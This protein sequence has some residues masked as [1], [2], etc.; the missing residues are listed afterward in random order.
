[1][2]KIGYL[3]LFLIFTMTTSCISNK[4]NSNIVYFSNSDYKLTLDG[5][6]GSIR[7]IEKD[8]YLMVD[9]AGTR[10]PL[11]SVRLRDAQNKGEIH[12]FNAL[13]A[14][15]CQIGQRKDLITM[16]FSDFPQ[17]DVQV[18]VTVAVSKDSPYMR[19]N[20][21]ITNNTPYLIDHIDFPNVVVPNDLVANGGTGRIFWPAQEGCLIE[22]MDIRA[23]SAWLRYTPIEYP[24]RGFGGRYPITAQMQYMAYYNAN[25]GLYM[26]TH[27]EDFHPKGIEYNPTE[28]NGIKLDFRLFA[29]GSGK[30]TYKLPYD[31]V[32]GVF[33]G[34]WY[35]ASMIYRDWRESSNMPVPP[36]IVDNPRLPDWYFES[37]VVVTYPVRGHMDTG[38]MS[39]NEFFPYTKGLKYI[40]KYND[41]FDSKIMA[42]LMHWEGSAPWAPPYVWPPYGGEKLYQ[43]FVDSLHAK[44]N[45][46]GLYASGIGYTLQSNNDPA[47]NMEQEFREKHLD[48]IMN[49][50][51]D[52]TLATNGV[53]TGP[54]AQRIGYDMCPANEFVKEV[55]QDQISKIVQSKT[56]YIQYFD[57]NL[58][59]ASYPC[60]GTNHGHPYGPGA[61]QSDAMQDIYKGVQEILDD[62]GYKPLIGCEGAAAEPYLSYLLY[63]DVRSPVNLMAGVPVPAFAFVYHE[64]VNNFMGNQVGVSAA[65]DISQSPANYLQR[66][67]YA[68]CAG[69]MLTVILRG[70]GD[71]IWNWGMKWEADTPDQ[72]QLIQLIKNLNSWRTGAG[73]NFLVTG[74][75]M[76]PLAFEGA[77]N[78]PMITKKG[79]RNINFPS[80]FTSSWQFN[81]RNAQFLVNYLP[82]EQEI[83]INAGNMK[84]AMIYKNSA[85]TEGEILVER[86]LKIAPL[87]AVMILY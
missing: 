1:M 27:D 87:S 43:D 28:N 76:K 62:S 58:G 4:R 11:F 30:G 32:I 3:M 13:Q 20:I 21:Q 64:Y 5:E 38:D 74:R 34:D 50:A 81:G 82:E 41:L 33:D 23:E 35:D 6:T 45:L 56:D 29:E 24:K 47:Y 48:Q 18:V 68:F 59:G 49:V 70:D 44:G 63:N 61:W 52:G 55:V 15:D 2:K 85:D 71:M 7:S 17:L 84:N 12:E 14:G 73:K 42:L 80:V 79:G 10:G 78:V 66:L 36:K 39:P 19:W 22:D 83:T 65:I 40:N 51:P 25:G 75:M 67:A 77:T 8:G 37:P 9:T 60:Y 16:T 31:V 86:R 53:C 54:K 69:D 72:E 57:Q 26:A 46:A